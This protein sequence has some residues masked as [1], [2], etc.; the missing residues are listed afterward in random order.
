MGHYLCSRCLIFLLVSAS[1]CVCVCVSG[2]MFSVFQRGLASGLHQQVNQFQ[3]S[4]REKK[5]NFSRH[6]SL[7]RVC[8]PS[9]Q[10]MFSDPMCFFFNMTKPIVSFSPSIYPLFLPPPHPYRPLIE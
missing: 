5:I 2:F 9:Q 1:V 8:T 7:N 3:N 4:E 10:P 6:Q